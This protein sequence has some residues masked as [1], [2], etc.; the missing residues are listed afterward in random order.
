MIAACLQR[1]AR[2]KKPATGPAEDKKNTG[3]RPFVFGPPGPFQEAASDLA[4]AGEEER[5][6][7]F[8]A[9]GPDAQSNI[10]FVM[11]TERLV[12]VSSPKPPG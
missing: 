4:L 11:T 8:H 6:T 3:R 1:R 9:G 12:M 5:L 2:A 7:H 10:T